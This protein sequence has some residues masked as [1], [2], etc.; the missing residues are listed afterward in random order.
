MAISMNLWSVE[1]G[2]LKEIQKSRV[3]LESQLENW[4]CTDPMLLN[5]DVM[6]VGRQV[7]TTF[8]GYIDLLAL[9]REGDLVVIELKRDKTPRDIVAQCLDY[10]SW[11][12]DLGYDDICEIYKQYKEKSLADD[13][14]SFFDDVI[15]ETLNENH[16]MIIVA[17]SLDESTERIISYLTERH[18]IRLCLH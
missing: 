4:V 15:P 10:A 6:I 5:L 12:C 3:N 8:G 16:Q 2:A 13:F 9:T 17:A 14:S 1:N 18:S 11:V 7:H